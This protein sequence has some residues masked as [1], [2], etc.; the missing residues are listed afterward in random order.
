MSI[1]QW[2]ITWLGRGGQGAVTASNILAKAAFIEGFKDVQSF[3]FFGAERRGAPVK[4]YTR[5]G[6]TAIHEFTSIYSADI[7]IVLDWSLLSIVHPDKEINTGGY[8]IVNS[9]CSDINAASVK[10]LKVF[11]VDA[12][13]IAF[14][15]N[16][17]VAG[18][19]VVNTC[20]LGAFSKATGLV[21]LKN[22]LTVVEETW[23]G[24]FLD[25]NI[26]ATKLA[27]EKCQML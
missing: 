15:I 2:D 26:E 13:T 24:E 23:S 21:K 10:D 19:P 7:F 17:T 8:L 9:P 5:I 27:Y 18:L 14:N 22:I 6:G 20:M 12:T 16:L 4:A 25:K 1:R 11:I 3:P